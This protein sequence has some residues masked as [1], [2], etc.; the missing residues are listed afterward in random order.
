VTG[1]EDLYT[2]A[3]SVPREAWVARWYDEGLETPGEPL[4]PDEQVESERERLKK[5]VST[6]LYAATIPRRLGG[7][8][9]SE[10]LA[11]DKKRC[12]RVAHAFIQSYKGWDKRELHPILDDEIRQAGAQLDWTTFSAEHRVA[13]STRGIYVVTWA[14]RSG[15][16]RWAKKAA[17]NFLNEQRW[18]EHAMR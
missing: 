1:L 7:E 18:F 12:R 17:T 2:N 16:R 5:L 14:L 10:D 11:L 15:Q 6:V 8:A 3:E 4:I 9:T 13:I